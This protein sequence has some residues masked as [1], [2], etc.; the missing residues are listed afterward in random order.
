MLDRE[1]FLKLL[2]EDR[3]KACRLLA[4]AKVEEWINDGEEEV[5]RCLGFWM[6]SGHNLGDDGFLADLWE[7]TCGED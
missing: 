6:C 2:A 4:E 1:A 3:L 5:A 7:N